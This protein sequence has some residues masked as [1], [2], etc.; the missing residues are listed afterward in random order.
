MSFRLLPTIIIINDSVSSISLRSILT[1]LPKKSLINNG[2][3]DYSTIPCS[4]HF[5]IIFEE[6]KVED[7]Y[8]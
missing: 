2:F 3:H 4:H 6:Q 7:T 5:V 1:G 8:A